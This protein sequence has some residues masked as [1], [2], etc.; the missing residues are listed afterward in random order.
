MVKIESDGVTAWVNASDGSCIGRFGRM[1]VD[2]HTTITSQM[3]GSG[4]CLECT[5]GP[6]GLAEWRLFQRAMSQH[7]GVAVS[8]EHMPTR[9]VARVE[10]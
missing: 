7:Y 1:G 9:L 2:V 3:A 4:Q 8:D 5:H 10:P 6:V